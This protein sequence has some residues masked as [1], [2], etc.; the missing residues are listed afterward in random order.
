LQSLANDERLFALLISAESLDS[1]PA[2]HQEPA[3]FEYAISAGEGTLFEYGVFDIEG[4]YQAIDV[5]DCRIGGDKVLIFAPC[6]DDCETG[7]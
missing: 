5:V 4:V 2:I 3:M 7:Q 1:P 6:D